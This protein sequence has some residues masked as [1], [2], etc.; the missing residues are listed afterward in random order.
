MDRIR[1]WRS[2]NGGS[3]EKVAMHWKRVDETTVPASSR[4]LTYSPASGA[5][6]PASLSA[7][8]CTDSAQQSI[9]LQSSVTLK[10]VGTSI[11][12]NVVKDL[13]GVPYIVTLDDQTTKFDSFAS[14]QQCTSDFHASNLTETSH[15]VI[16]THNGNSTLQANGRSTLK[17]VSFSYTSSKNTQSGGSSK[18]GPIVG[19]VLGV[20]A[21]LL[22]C[23][24]AWWYVRRKRPI[25]GKSTG[26]FAKSQKEAIREPFEV[27]AVL[28][29][30]HEQERMRASHDGPT[31]FQSVK[32]TTTTALGS[33]PQTAHRTKGSDPGNTSRFVRTSP[34]ASLTSANG[35]RG[36]LAPGGTHDGAQNYTN[37]ASSVVNSGSE[38]PPA[39]SLVHQY[40][41][42]SGTDYSSDPSSSAS[43]P[44]T[45]ITTSQYHPSHHQPAQRRR[46]PPA[47]ST[48]GESVL[49]DDPD[50]VPPPSY[51]PPPSNVGH[52]QLLSRITEGR[53]SKAIYE[54]TA[55]DSSGSSTNWLS[56]ASPRRPLPNAQGTANTGSFSSHPPNQPTLSQADIDGIARRVVDL[57]R[58]APSSTAEGGDVRGSIASDSRYSHVSTADAQNPQV[59]QAVRALLS[60]HEPASNAPTA[61][62]TNTNWSN[63][64][65]PPPSAPR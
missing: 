26:V 56:P 13:A 29:E 19:A 46:H 44:A 11:T 50:Y 47:P 28:Q 64:S 5:W 20:V 10:F 43:P 65:S 33:L 9:S 25:A 4:Q 16:V 8:S 40:P 6:N 7:G 37:L 21:L 2:R 18:A 36:N 34:W 39:T 30:R 41:P 22:I 62:N 24:A 63:T 23:A 31:P 60:Q 42:G 15:T 51:S 38:S 54:G 17:F 35:S 12:V 3:I 55:E 52:G 45:V 53:D 14:S 59:Q 32:N 58:S 49:I 57:M 61:P 48:V 27:D 1:S